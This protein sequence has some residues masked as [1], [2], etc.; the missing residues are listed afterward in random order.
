MSVFTIDGDFVTSFGT[1]GSELG[2]FDG[3]FGLA[4]DRKGVLYVS[5]FGNKRVQLFS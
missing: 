4:V 5:D 1:E 2:Q 3:P